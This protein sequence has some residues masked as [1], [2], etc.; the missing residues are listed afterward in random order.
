MPAPLHDS[1]RF[2]PKPNVLVRELDGEA[3]LLDLDSGR[4]FGLN[5][6]GLRIWAGLAA[7]RPVGEIVAELAREHRVS[8][9]ALRADL[10]ELVAELEREALVRRLG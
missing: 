1:D 5:A 2:G 4:Y 6:S 3:V 7:G 10:S 9:E 8:A